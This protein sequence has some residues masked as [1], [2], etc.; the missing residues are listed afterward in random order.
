[1]TAL[2][3]EVLEIFVLAGASICMLETVKRR[4]YRQEEAE[5]ATVVPIGKVHRS[6]A[7]WTRKETCIV[8]TSSFISIFLTSVIFAVAD[9]NVLG[10]FT[11]PEIEM[12]D[13][14]E[15][16]PKTHATIVYDADVKPI[17]RAMSLSNM[18]SGAD[19][20]C[21][22]SMEGN[23]REAHNVFDGDPKTRWSSEWSDEQ[24]L[25]F[26]ISDPD[27]CVSFKQIAILWETASAK[28]YAVESSLTG[29]TWHPIA[30]F[31]PERKN[32]K[33]YSDLISFDPPVMA[34]FFRIKGLQRST[35][36][37]YSIFNIVPIKT[38][39]KDGPKMFN[40][41][42]RRCKRLIKA[43]AFLKAKPEQP[44]LECTPNVY[45]PPKGHVYSRGSGLDAAST[46]HFNVYPW[47]K[48]FRHGRHAVTYRPTF[49]ITPPSSNTHFLQKAIERFQT[50]VSSQKIVHLDFFPDEKE[51]SKHI[52]IKVHSD[53]LDPP[54]IIEKDE[55]Y[56]LSIPSD[57][58]DIH[59]EAWSDVGVLRALTTLQQLTQKVEDVD[60]LTD[61]CFVVRG[62]PLLIEDAPAAKYRGVLIDSARVFL[63]ESHIKYVIDVMSMMKLNVLH[64]HLSD[65][66]GFTLRL[67]RWQNQPLWRRGSC[68]RETTYSHQTV[69]EILEYAFDRGILVVPE[70]DLPG[71]ALSWQKAFP[72]KFGTTDCGEWGV[73][74]DVT[75]E[76]GYEVVSSV[77]TELHDWFKLKGKYMHLGGDEVKTECWA[78]DEGVQARAKALRVDTTMLGTYFFLQAF[79]LLQSYVD[80]TVKPI[81]W[82]ESAINMFQVRDQFVDKIKIS[83]IIHAW[84]T[85]FYQR[86]TALAEEKQT[87]VISSAGWYLNEDPEENCPDFMSCYNS[88]PPSFS[89]KL[90]PYLLGGVAAVWE[91]KASRFPLVVDRL[92]AIAE[93]LWSD[94]PK[95]NLPALGRARE[96]FGWLGENHVDIIEA[97]AKK[98]DISM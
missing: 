36:Y 8:L 40:A 25:W 18:S 34:R 41:G 71:H 37:G 63:E 33:V 9:P 35:E 26:R 47:P 90:H 82:E 55:V 13:K 7:C 44:Y 76:K 64:W 95:T 79:N 10:Y 93:R 5:R 51:E 61:F 66:L 94:R 46:V 50:A 62:T 75:Q 70:L 32:W 69:K 11:V 1:M 27:P 56:R 42:K 86:T 30:V 43:I 6:G 68:S 65:D 58:Q 20:V 15:V 52:L 85:K 2:T 22:S 21:G 89:R 81:L 49:S 60:C 97:Q 88:G 28:R 92:A 67:Q 29:H 87:Q 73:P 17:Y 12:Y 96:F 39:R 14:L 24:W 59:V 16:H 3:V 84:R 54:N 80:A 53:N 77:Y 98:G 72:N 23:C 91:T 31:A 19:I 78:N 4:L 48:V 74:I 83:F 45:I 38:T 57:G